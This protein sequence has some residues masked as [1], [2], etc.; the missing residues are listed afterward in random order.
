[1]FYD[2]QSKSAIKYDLLAY[3]ATSKENFEKVSG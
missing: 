3:V 1:M 2:S